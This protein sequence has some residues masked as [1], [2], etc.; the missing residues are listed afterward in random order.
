MAH[1]TNSNISRPRVFMKINFSTLSFLTLTQT[2]TFKCEFG[3][4]CKDVGNLKCKIGLGIFSEVGRGELLQREVMSVMYS[5][6]FFV[7]EEVW[8]D[9][10]RRYEK[11]LVHCLMISHFI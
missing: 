5:C 7:G 4:I 3:Q 9:G 10:N 8:D 11:M 1:A 2:C 6:F